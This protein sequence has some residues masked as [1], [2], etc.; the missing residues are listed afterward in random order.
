MQPVPQSV[1]STARAP[2]KRRDLPASTSE[3]EIFYYLGIGHVFFNK[4][5]GLLYFS[6]LDRTPVLP[7]LHAIEAGAPACTLET[8]YLDE[9]HV[10]FG[11][12]RLQLPENL[13]TPLLVALSLKGVTISYALAQ[14]AGEAPSA[15]PT[16]ST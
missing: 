3:R 16:L 15:P 14:F 7:T 4:A 11:G 13:S 1:R 9:H 6:E 2:C 10:F 12:Y 8:L 5:R